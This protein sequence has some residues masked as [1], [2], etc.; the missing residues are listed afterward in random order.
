MSQIR[1]VESFI[2]AFNARDVDA[3]MAFFAPG[4]VYHNMPGPPVS[5]TPAIREL[6]QSFVGPAETVDWENLAI[7]EQGNKVLTER[8]DRFVI[9]G[10]NVALPVMGTFEFTDGKISAWRDYFDMATWKRQMES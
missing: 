2:A 8:I 7:A 5:G 4:A 6:I 9:G 10:K 3:V 1:V